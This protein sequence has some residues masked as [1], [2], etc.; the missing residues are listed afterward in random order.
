[1]EKKGKKKQTH[2]K[3]STPAGLIG[4][5][6]NLLVDR[7]AGV[8]EET[9]QKIDNWHTELFG[10]VIDLLQTLC[11]AMKDVRVMVNK[12][13]TQ[14]QEA[15][16]S[17]DHSVEIQASQQHRKVQLVLKALDSVTVELN[18]TI[19]YI[20]YVGLDKSMLPIFILHNIQ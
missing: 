19:Q 7:M 9:C 1:M 6:Y 12:K 10:G 8:I 16:P 3:D 18:N 5:D 4:E 2:V 13:V 15:S 11:K 17:N 20:D 14:L